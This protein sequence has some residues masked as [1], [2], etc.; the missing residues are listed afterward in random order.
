M[1]IK[2][3]NAQFLVEDCEKGIIPEVWDLDVYR[4]KHQPLH[5]VVD[6]GAHKG[7]FSVYCAMKGALVHAYEPLSSNY[8]MLLH[9]IEINGVS[10]EVEVHNL[11]VWSTS[12][13]VI[14]FVKQDHDYSS[15]YSFPKSV[16]SKITEEVSSVTLETVFQSIPWCDVLKL[17]CESSEYEILCSTPDAVLKRVGYITAE[18]HFNNMKP[19]GILDPS[20]YDQLLKRLEKLFYI[21]FDP[22]PNGKYSYIYCTNKEYHA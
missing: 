20:V 10:N 1:L 12:A 16:A 5:T 9:N 6:I 18:L 2:T 3:H 7:I 21:E 4:I 8:K 22:L 15:V 17:D 13:P 19:G 14:M 11:A